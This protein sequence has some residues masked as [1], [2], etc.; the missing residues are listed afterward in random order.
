MKLIGS[1][2][3]SGIRKGLE[4]NFFAFKEH[5]RFEEILKVIG[6]GV[7]DVATVQPLQ[8]FPDEGSVCM[9]LLIFPDKIAHI[10]VPDRASEPVELEENEIIQSPSQNRSRSSQIE[11][12]VAFDLIS[13]RMNTKR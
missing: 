10:D 2:T 11:L 3:E 8:I 6:V 12:A 7:G 1:L 4:A 5:S 13:I 9:S